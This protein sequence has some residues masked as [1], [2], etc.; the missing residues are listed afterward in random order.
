MIRGEIR[1]HAFKFPDKRRP[2]LILTRDVLIPELNVATVAP[3]TNTMRDHET[4]VILDTQDGMDETC[5]INLTNIQT[6]SKD[7]IEGF[8][9]R[10]SD[11]RIQEVFEAIKFAFGFDK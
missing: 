8:I 3:I 5:A 11:E 6:V 2:V 4:Q 10:L 9:T 7:R 1:Y